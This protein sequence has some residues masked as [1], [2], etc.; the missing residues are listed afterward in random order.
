MAHHN[1]PDKRF[2]YGKFNGKYAAILS[3]IIRV[4]EAL[5]FSSLLS[6]IPLT[7]QCVEETQREGERDRVGP[8]RRFSR[9]KGK[10]GR[11][12]IKI[13]IYRPS[14]P[15]GFRRIVSARR[16]QKYEPLASTPCR[17]TPRFNGVAHNLDSDT[18]I[19]ELSSITRESTAILRVKSLANCPFY[20]HYLRT[21]RSQPLLKSRRFER[22]GNSFLTSASSLFDTVCLSSLVTYD[23]SRTHCQ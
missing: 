5:L 20:E 8:A 2:P 22:T 18:A 23:L 10:L 14:K 11:R 9:T 13:R 3:G 4:L 6:V 15:K 7:V 1:R 21:V 12:F 19:R 16:R 17:V